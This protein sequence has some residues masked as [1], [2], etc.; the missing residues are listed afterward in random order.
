MSFLFLKL[1]TKV[2]GN[3]T[4]L[5]KLEFSISE[6]SSSIL[7]FTTFITGRGYETDNLRIL[8]TG[9]LYLSLIQNSLLL[10]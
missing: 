1:H 5:L 4:G 3:H 8:M 6:L 2:E 10:L 9:S 7:F